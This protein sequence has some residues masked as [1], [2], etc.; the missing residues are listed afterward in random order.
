MQ[1]SPQATRTQARSPERGT[2][3]R[4]QTQKE[5]SVHAYAVGGRWQIGTWLIA[6]RASFSLHSQ[7][8][9]FDP[10]ATYYVAERRLDHD[11]RLSDGSDAADAATAACPPP[12]IT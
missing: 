4:I 3:Q 12:G 7:T 2:P 8:A 5:N 1:A 11:R 6:N 10:H 9:E